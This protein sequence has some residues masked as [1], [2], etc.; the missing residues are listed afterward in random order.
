M[1]IAISY[2][3][4]RLFLDMTTKNAL[5]PLCPKI[6]KE[7]NHVYINM[8]I[9]DNIAPVPRK[10]AQLNLVHFFTLGPDLPPID[11]LP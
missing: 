5:T 11:V 7:I 8:M 6:A 2:G 3:Q 10:S 4:K 9:Y 1:I